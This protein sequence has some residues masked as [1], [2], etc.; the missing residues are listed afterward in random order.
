M[1]MSNI[2]H[3]NRYKY[4]FLKLI[5]LH[6]SRA[7]KTLAEKKAILAE[8]QAEKRKQER[9]EKV[10]KEI[11]MREGFIQMLKEFKELTTM[12]RMSWRKALPYFE[13]DNRLQSVAERDR[14]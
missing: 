13:G 9:A 11:K 8:F 4:V 10:K 2:I 14:E 3:D 12:P 5:V 6:F 1:T 7:L